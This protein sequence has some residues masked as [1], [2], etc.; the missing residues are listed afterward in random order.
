MLYCVDNIE[1][2]VLT[3]FAESFGGVCSSQAAVKKSVG[4]VNIRLGMPR[5]KTSIIVRR[6]VDDEAIVQSIKLL[7]SWLSAF[8]IQLTGTWLASSSPSTPPYLAAPGKK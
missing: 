3:I 6:N 1:N 4:S 8:S 2:T 5:K 7:I